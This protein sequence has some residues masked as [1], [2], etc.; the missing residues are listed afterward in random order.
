MSNAIE[1]AIYHN[2]LEY[3]HHAEERR[4]WNV[5]RDIPWSEANTGISDLVADV[6]ETFC[7]V[8]SFLPDY[9][10]KML[11]MIRKSRGRAWFHINWGYE[12]SKHSMVLREW[13]MASGKRTE[14]QLKKL[15][16]DL[17][18]SEWELPFGTPRQMICYT[19]IQELATHVNYRQ[20]RKVAERE[21]DPA[22]MKLLLL[23]AKDEA[24]HYGFF[25]KALQVFMEHDPAG[26]VEDL[27]YVFKHFRMPAGSE[28]P[29]YDQRAR[30]LA[31]HGIYGPREYVALVREPLLK[32]LGLTRDDLRPAEESL[33]RAEER[34]RGGKL[35]IA[36]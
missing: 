14:A 13:L 24:A 20:L 32:K 9:T 30:Q 17:W 28:I 12:E 15:D 25:L 36:R 23:L 11:L 4:R 5:K 16:E 34:D 2:Y 6:V 3:F 29:D 35:I 1:D 21:H 10:S 19:T 33:R 7:A 18:E 31:E 27:A 22:L 26:T 8:E